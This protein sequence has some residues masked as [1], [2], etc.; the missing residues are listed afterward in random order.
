MNLETGLTLIILAIAV[1]LFIS[2][3]LRVDLI[4]LL[5]LG[6]LTVL[7]LVTPN[8]ALSGFSNPA[9]VTIWAV[10]ILGGGLRL[11]G[12]E[13]LL[14]DPSVTY[15]WRR[16]DMDAYVASGGTGPVYGFFDSWNKDILFHC[17]QNRIHQFFF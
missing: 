16:A 5:V 4:A 10:F 13:H 11:G 12:V 1:I 2:E 3:R 17:F 9:V 14:N 6:G 7:G 15:V 8:E